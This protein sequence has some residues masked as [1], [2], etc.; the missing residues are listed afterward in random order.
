MAETKIQ[1]IVEQLKR[2]SAVGGVE[3]SAV[4]ARNGL[5][6]ASDLASSVDERRFGAMSATMMGAVETAA[7]TLKKGAIKRVTAEMENGTMIAMGAGPKAILLVS[8]SKESNLGMLM[9]EMEDAIESIRK[10]VEE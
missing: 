3:G 1:R 5:L 9:I 8:A 7:I 2:I 10:I 4:V 6:M